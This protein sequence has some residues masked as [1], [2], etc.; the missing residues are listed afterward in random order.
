MNKVIGI[1]AALFALVIVVITFT[2]PVEMADDSL[3][4]FAIGVG[5][6]AGVFVAV[7]VSV[8]LWVFQRAYQETQIAF[9]GCRTGCTA[10]AEY[11]L[12]HRAEAETLF[13]APLRESP[14]RDLFESLIQIK[15][16]LMLEDIPSFAQWREHSSEAMRTTN[17][18]WESLQA[19]WRN[20]AGPESPPTL[21]EFTGGLWERLAAVD[22][23]IQRKEWITG[24]LKPAE[25]AIIGAIEASALILL[26]AFVLGLLA[27]LTS[28][29]GLE[30][31][32]NSFSA[33]LLIVEI[34]IGAFFVRR[35]LARIR[36]SPREFMHQLSASLGEEQIANHSGG[37]TDPSEAQEIENPAEPPTPGDGTGTTRPR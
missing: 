12:S 11:V 2:T 13:R 33:Y 8:L 30:D 16:A 15:Q 10:L 17:P 23:S 36:K 25:T 31:V 34:G 18:E 35:S 32:A 21:S 28:G 22:Q 3:A 14:G 7:L 19:A 4:S 29:A 9:D 5:T 20:L 26:T 37:T 27:S 1:L 6:A 24:W